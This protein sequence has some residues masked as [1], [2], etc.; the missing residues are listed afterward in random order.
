MIPS[1]KCAL[2]VLLASANAGLAATVNLDFSTASGLGAFSVDVAGQGSGTGETVSLTA[3]LAPTITNNDLKSVPAG[4]DAI[5]SVF[6]AS[7]NNVTLSSHFG[8]SGS[9]N[10]TGLDSKGN[11]YSLL[12]DLTYEENDF[13]NVTA[14]ITDEIATGSGDDVTGDVRF[15]IWAGENGGGHRIS[16]A[17]NTFA[18]GADNFSI[19]GS[20]T[21]NSS[22]A[23]SSIGDDV[24]FILGFRDTPNGTLLI[25][26]LNFSA[27]LNETNTVDF[28]AVPEPTSTSLLGIATIGLLTRRKRS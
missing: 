3:T 18:S 12:V 28:T 16:G 24:G 1:T 8:W 10:L 9:I 25:D 4:Y 17:T 13:I 7:A 19:V 22:T 6:T 21:L 26:N 23:S 11:S 14:D 2:L 5:Q 15:A 27:E 20:R